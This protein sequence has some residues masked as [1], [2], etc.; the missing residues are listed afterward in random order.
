VS[1]TAT[2]LEL[3]STD[4]GAPCCRRTEVAAMLR[5]GG[6]MTTH[7]GRPVV[8]VALDTQAAAD[9]LCT[10]LAEVFRRKPMVTV[11][12][13]PSQRPLYLVRVI[14][15]AEILI[16][17]IGLL[18]K[19]GRPITGLPSAVTIGK[20]CD[21]AAAWRGAILVAGSM[22]KSRRKRILQ[23][24]CSNEQSAVGLSV[25]AGRLG[26]KPTVGMKRGRHH[27][28]LRGQELTSHL[29]K[30]LGANESLADWADDPATGKN[31]AWI[32][33]LPGAN[34][35]RKTAAASEVV[36]RTQWALDVLD[37][38]R[39]IDTSL[40]YTAHLRVEHEQASLQ[41]LALMHD[42]AL[43]KG[44]VSK[45]LDRLFALA[46]QRAAAIGLPLEPTTT[47]IPLHA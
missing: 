17:Q 42:P 5:F 6:D 2:K 47:G 45:R 3:A 38:E 33:T 27:V 31:D 23:V 4:K 10:S 1:I 20:A 39:F 43:T 40:L 44:G 18:D 12:E 13:R 26:L 32:T 46:N 35:A 15:D 22:V 41:D 8:T 14:R 24:A 25:V 21:A 9:R 36:G 30:R 16:R 11:L 7:G 37:G 29:L 34:E 28:S 19:L